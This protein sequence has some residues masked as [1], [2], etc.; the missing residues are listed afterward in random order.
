M[1]KNIRRIIKSLLSYNGMTI[2]KLAQ[3]MSEKTGK[4]YT[5]ASLSSKLK[6]QSLSLYEAYI[7]AE[8]LGYE[9]KFDKKSP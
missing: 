4:S 9:L 5:L 6:I 1:E 8:I 2:K 7:I 3:L